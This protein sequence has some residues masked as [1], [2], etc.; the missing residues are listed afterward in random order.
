MSEVAEKIKAM[1]SAPSCCKELKAAGQHYLD[2]LGTSNEASAKA[3][4]L[5]EI[6]E[7]ILS[8]D[9]LIGFLES[10][11]GAKALGPGLEPFLA[12]AKEAKAAG[13]KHCICAACADAV[14]VKQ[15]LG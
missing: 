11:A 15:L 13:E 10:P 5:A 12:K 6:D 4:L 7:D 8:I 1:I 3:A 9:Q 14:A 2:A